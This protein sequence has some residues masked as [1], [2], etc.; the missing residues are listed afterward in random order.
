MMV[1]KR[2]DNWFCKSLYMAEPHNSK[3]AA[4]TCGLLL[5]QHQMAR[6]SLI[7]NACSCDVWSPSLR[8]D[9]P[10]K[11][12]DMRFPHGGNSSAYFI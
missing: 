10:N 3:F 1:C 12:E 4:V 6:Q 5:I 11:N 7:V 2:H 8:I 9:T